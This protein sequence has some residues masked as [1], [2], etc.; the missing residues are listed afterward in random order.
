MWQ[1]HKSS[2]NWDSHIYFWQSSQEQAAAD[3]EEDEDAYDDDDAGEEA[4]DYKEEAGKDDDANNVAN[5]TV[6][7]EDGVDAGKE[8][9]KY[10]EKK[11]DQSADPAQHPAG[12]SPKDLAPSVVST[13][14]PVPEKAETNTPAASNSTPESEST[15]SSIFFVACPHHIIYIVHFLSETKFAKILTEINHIIQF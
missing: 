7:D 11:D 4:E 3:A 8:V 14:T 6:E 1:P 10:V 2:K 15:L 12:S 13:S 5:E 9:E